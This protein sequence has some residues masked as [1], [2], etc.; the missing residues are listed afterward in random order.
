MFSKEHFLRTQYI[1]DC[2]IRYCIMKFYIN[3]H[4]LRFS[5]PFSF[6]TGFFFSLCMLLFFLVIT[7]NF[8]AIS[9]RIRMIFAKLMS[10]VNVSFTSL[11][12]GILSSIYEIEGLS[13]KLCRQNTKLKKNLF[14]KFFFLRKGKFSNG[15]FCQAA[16]Y[17]TSISSLYVVAKPV[18]T[19]YYRK[20]LWNTIFLERVPWMHIHYEF[21]ILIFLKYKQSADSKH[22]LYYLLN[23]SFIILSLI[24]FGWGLGS[25]SLDVIILVR[26][27]R[28][29][30]T[31]YA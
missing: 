9:Q 3:W 1:Y 15:K 21:L 17:A 22:A 26:S 8:S 7:L 27:F 10:S 28:C 4:F 12:I 19:F 2:K 23:V 13:K 25:F 18:I 5:S 24:F 11:Q 20:Y 29:C 30:L 6:S 16:A 14:I 31:S